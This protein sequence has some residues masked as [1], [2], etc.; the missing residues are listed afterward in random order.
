MLEVIRQVHAIYAAQYDGTNAAEIV[1][2]F[3]AIVISETGGTLTYADDEF[4]QTYTVDEGQWVHWVG[5]TS[6][7][8]FVQDT[9]LD[10][11]YTAIPLK[12]LFTVT[13][14]GAIPASTLGGQQNITVNLDSPLQAGYV[15]LIFLR[16]APNVLGGHTVLGHTIVDEDTV[17]VHIQSAALSLSG[18][19]V[20]VVA[21]ELR[22]V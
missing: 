16:G 21:Q 1:A 17:T 13:G 9:L 19:S 10:F 8:T 5:L 18:G 14:S 7:E 15:P 6:S 12:S 22:T 3:N 20:F 4:S 11:P 2:E